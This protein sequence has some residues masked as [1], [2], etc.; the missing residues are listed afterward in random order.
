MTH[1]RLLGAIAGLALISARPPAAGSHPKLTQADTVAIVRAVWESMPMTSS[2]TLDPAPWLW[3]PTTRD[4][5]VAIRLSDAVVKALAQQ[6]LPASTRRPRGDDTVVFHITKLKNGGR[7]ELQLVSEWTTVLGTGSRR[8][9][10]GGG[11]VAD[12]RVTRTSTGW[13]AKVL[14]VEVGDDVCVPIPPENR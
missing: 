8:C 5:I 1:A 14:T 11:D 10:T 13:T 4:S 6:G 2:H 3:T 12:F 9:R 7:V